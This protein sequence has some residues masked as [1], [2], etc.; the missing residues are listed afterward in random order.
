[1]RQGVRL[2]GE[3]LWCDVTAAMRGVASRTLADLKEQWEKRQG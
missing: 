1:M 3:D 2:R